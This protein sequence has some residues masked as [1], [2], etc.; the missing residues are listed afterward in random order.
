MVEDAL[1]ATL[2]ETTWDANRAMGA[3]SSAADYGSI[4]AGEVSAGE[5]DQRQHWKL[6]HHYLGKS[7]NAAGVAAARQRFGQ[8]QG[9]T[10]R[11]EARRH[12]FETHQLASDQ[13]D[14]LPSADLVR[15]LVDG[16]EVRDQGSD[17]PSVLFGHFLRFN[18]W[19]E[20]KSVR[21]GHFMER[22]APGSVAKTLEK[23]RTRMRVTFQHGHDPAMGDQVLGIPSVLREDELG[24]YY[25]VP[26]FDGIPPLVM[27]G[28]R[29]GAYGSSFRFRVERMEVEKN[30]GES[31]YNP[32]GL[33]E[34]TVLEAAVPEFGPVTYPAYE[35]ATAGIRSLTDEWFFGRLAEDKERLLAVIEFTRDTFRTKDE[36]EAPSVDAGNTPPDS[37]RK[38]PPDRK[39]PLFGDDRKEKP[40]WLL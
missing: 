14:R 4:C 7:A 10:N 39:V 28:L 34:R 23:N 32:D 11:E 22:F 17:D 37:E 26:L 13:R 9:L 1:R 18:E 29:N 21:E 3:C 8:T 40:P 38:I 36:D 20:I 27:S 12:L 15:G 6:P 2:D 33:P 16:Y 30:P 24:A 5:P 25:E 31:E 35:G 19:A